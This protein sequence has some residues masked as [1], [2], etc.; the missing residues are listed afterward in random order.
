ML[1]CDLTS[2]APLLER[3]GEMRA[4]EVDGSVELR[5][6]AFAAQPYS[7]EAIWTGNMLV[8]TPLSRRFRRLFFQ[9]CELSQPGVLLVSGPAG[10]GK[11]ETMKDAA[12][13]LGAWSIVP[14]PVSTRHRFHDYFSKWLELCSAP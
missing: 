14:P 5:C 4:M 8:T 6:C 12:A 1:K 2:G 7:F 11:T 3:L 9:C 13:E 10:T